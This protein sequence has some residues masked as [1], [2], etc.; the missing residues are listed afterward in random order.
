MAKRTHTVI[1]GILALIGACKVEA[2]TGL[3]PEQKEV[4]INTALDILT[5][6]DAIT[7]TEIAD[8]GIEFRQEAEQ[9]LQDNGIDPREFRRGQALDGLRAMLEGGDEQHKIEG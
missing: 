6:S 9:L 7:V 8:E 3:T 1:S 5:D 4:E 2:S